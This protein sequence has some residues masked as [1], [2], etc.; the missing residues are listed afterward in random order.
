MS[1]CGPLRSFALLMVQRLDQRPILPALV[2]AGARWCA[3]IAI[4][5]VGKTCEQEF[6]EPDCRGSA[7]G[8]IEHCGQRAYP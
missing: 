2:D 1:R 5:V 4:G 3:A 8:E 7:R 6:D